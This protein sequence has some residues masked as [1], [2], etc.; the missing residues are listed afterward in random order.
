MTTRIMTCLRNFLRDNK[1]A[2]LPLIAM[3]FIPILLSIGAGV[4]FARAYMVR[5]K[6]QEA[7]DSAALA[8]RRVMTQ[9]DIET[10]RSNITAFMAFN[11]PNGLYDTSNI[12]TRITKPDIGTVRVEAETEVPTTILQIMGMNSFKISVFSEAKQNFDNIDIM[13]VL[14]TT[15]SMNE[16]LGGQTRLEALRAA[17]RALYNQLKTPQAEL[18]AQGLRMRIGIVP[19]SN[20]VNVGRLLRAKNPS[21]IQ[22]TNVP[23]WHWRATKS[24]FFTSWSFRRA[25]YN[26][27]SFVNGGQLGNINNNNNR[28]SSTWTG[29]I[30]ERATDPLI[31]A[32]DPRTGPTP[33]A[34]DLD[35]DMIPNAS[36]LTKWKPYIF[37]PL[38]GAVN[39]Y[40]PSEA[41]ELRAMNQTDLDNYLNGLVAQGSTYHDI[42][43]IW[44]TRMISS[45]G[46]FGPDNP[47][48]YKGRTVN[49]YIIFMTDGEISTPIDFCVSVSWSGACN[50]NTGNHVDAYSAWGIEFFDKRIGALNNADNDARHTTRFLMACN[51][52]KARNVSIWTI[53]FGTGT[54]DSLTK[55]ASN[56]DQASTADN[57]TQLIEKFA[58]IGRNIGPLRLSK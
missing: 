25:T 56:A 36:D 38:N 46:V 14:D 58:E 11:F 45:G 4:D 1:G 17:V 8:G 27:T 12:V 32:N 16:M 50:S 51:E 18:E 26:L 21:Y 6:L 34:L 42:G 30:E 43:M 41:M 3:S 52:A 39:K 49:K 23:Y 5:A 15:G 31:I 40:C 35:I 29:C 47:A 55:C 37:D 10:A 44:G 54:V 19:Y 9:D 33:A 53:A 57:S 48:T 20:T 22:Q 13:L 7:V 28:S 2:V 24:W